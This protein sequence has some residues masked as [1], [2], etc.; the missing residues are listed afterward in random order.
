MNCET[1]FQSLAKH[2]KS[3]QLISFD[4]QSISL[5]IGHWLTCTIDTIK[6]YC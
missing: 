4:F 5:A 1:Q 2:N 3:H 6:S